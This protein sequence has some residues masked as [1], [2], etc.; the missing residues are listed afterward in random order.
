MK[1][2]PVVLFTL[3]L[4]LGA[5]SNSG[6][7]QA[8]MVS[9]L[10]S[11]E[12]TET[13]SITAQ[14]GDEDSDVDDAVDGVS[15]EQA[16]NVALAGS[17]PRPTATPLP[18]SFMDYPVI[19]NISEQ[20]IEIY[21]QG[22]SEGH[23]PNSFSK[24]GDCQNITTYFLAPFEDP[25]LYSLGD[26]YASLQDTIDYFF[27]SFSRESLA[28]AGGLNVAR[29][30]SPLHSDPE[31]CEPNEHPLACEV[32][33][34]NPSIAIVSLEENWGSRTAEEYEQYYRRVIEYLISENVLPILAT[35][36]DNL[37]GDNSFNEVIARLAGEYQV[38]LWNF[39]LAVQ[40]LPNHGLQE[41]GFH[42]TVAGPYLDD[43]AHMKSSWPWRNLT[44]LQSLN[45]VL[46]AVNNN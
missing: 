24:V 13:E 27:G 8:E 28:V 22:I 42:L 14:P 18:E 1:N 39:W 16:S 34:N 26:E 33:I 38:P 31:L 10:E 41:D 2:F 7:I 12:N 23:N 19:P 37:E 29:V 32:R 46:E 25:D 45:A 4:L 36:A 30:L 6:N 3:L 15:P 17:T 40:P 9:A 5:C 11:V 35:K 44:A 21:L 20:A 43:P